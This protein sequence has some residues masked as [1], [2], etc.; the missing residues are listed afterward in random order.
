MEGDLGAALGGDADHFERALRIAAGI[1][2]PP[3]LAVAADLQLELLRQGVDHRYADAV[4]TAG[5]LV[6][7]VVELA[8]G[9]QHG[10]RHFGRRPPF[11]R[12]HFGGDAAAIVN[13]GHRTI[14]VDG[15]L[16]QVAMAGQSLVDGIVNDLVDQVVEPRTRGGADVHGRALAYRGQPL[17]HLDAVCAILVVVL[18]CHVAPH[19]ACRSSML[20]RCT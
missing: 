1:A 13:H 6:G 9:V 11:G 2:L 15:H 14:E 10:Q 5:H 4:Q 19:A 8:A 17:E 16:D 3:D 7:V 20:P 18:N 12:V